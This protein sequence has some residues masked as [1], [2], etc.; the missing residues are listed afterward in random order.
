MN[1]RNQHWREFIMRILFII[2]LPVI[3][4]LLTVIFGQCARIDAFKERVS[5]RAAM[6]RA[7][8][9]AFCSDNK[10]EDFINGQRCVLLAPGEY[11]DYAC[12]QC[13]ENLMED[14]RR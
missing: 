4:I 10:A 8:V 9:E 13:K 14:I 6:S 12:Y 3:I 11:P 7:C 5:I 1:D 2:L